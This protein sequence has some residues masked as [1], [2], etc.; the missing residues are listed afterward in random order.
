MG[1]VITRH[2]SQF[3]KSSGHF[4][5]ATSA[6][7]D[8]VAITGEVMWYQSSEQARRG[9][10]GTC[11]SQMFWDG[12]GDNLS[13]FAGCFDGATGVMISGHILCA[14]KGDYYEITGGLPQADV[15]GPALTAQF[16]S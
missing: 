9:F 10:C 15:D 14:D 4:V 11:G 1:H 12:F 13:I 16:Y 6:I 2:C 8:R 5:A 3:R 7:C